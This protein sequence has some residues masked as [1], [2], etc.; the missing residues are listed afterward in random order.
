MLSEDKKTVLG[1]KAG[2]KKETAKPNKE[3]GVKGD[4]KK[5]R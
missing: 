5:S 2:A 1:I 4:E 3:A